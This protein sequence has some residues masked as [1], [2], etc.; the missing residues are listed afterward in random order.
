MI[1]L[2]AFLTGGLICVI[3]QLLLDKTALTPARI[4]VGFV[5]AGVL[6]SAIG[7]YAPLVEFAGAGASV[8]LS[9]FGHVLAK[10][11]REAV[12]HHGA[13]GILTGGLQASAAGICG[14]IVFALAAG[15]CF[16]SKDKS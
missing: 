7:L 5:T 14:A 4:L 13:L 15:L 2:K 16:H 8:P 9:G 12:D 11:V 6:L 1:Y 3:G 10:G